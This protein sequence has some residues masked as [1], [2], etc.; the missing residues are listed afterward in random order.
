MYLSIAL[1]SAPY[2]NLTYKALPRFPESFWKPGL[3]LAIPLGKGGSLRTGILLSVSPTN[4]LP[5]SIPIKTIAWPLEESP[6]IPHEL[7]LLMEEMSKRQG[8]SIGRMAA[9]FLPKGLK[10]L[11]VSLHRVKDNTASLLPIAA[12]AHFDESQKDELAKEM[13]AGTAKILATKKQAKDEECF[14]LNVDPPWPVRPNA[15]VQLAVLEYLFNHGPK[16][17]KH[18]A[19]ALGKGVTAALTSLREANAITLFREESQDTEAILSSNAPL[20]A[21]APPPFALNADQEKAL[22]H[23]TTALSSHTHTTSLLYGVTGSGKTAVYLALARTCLQSGRSVLLLVPEVALALKIL[24]D[25]K[26]LY[27]DLPVVLYH[28]YQPQRSREHLWR[29]LHSPH[30]LLVIGTRSALF[31][32]IHDLGLIILDEEHDSSFKQDDGLSYH[33][34][35]IAWFRASFNACLLVLGSATP[36]VR[37]FYAAKQGHLAIDP[38]PTRISGKALPPIELV[39]LAERNSLSKAVSLLA[40]KSLAILE[41]TLARNEQAVILLNRRGYAPQMF[42]VA[43]GKT[44]RCPDCEIG[45]TYH[46]ARNKLVCHFCGYTKDFPS[47]CSHCGAATFLPLGEG[48]ERITEELSSYLGQN[49]LRLDRDTTRRSGQM[50]AIL[51]AFANQEAPVLVGTQMLSKGH[52]FPN[53]TLVIAANADMGLSMPDYRAVERTFQLLLQSAGRAGRGAL[54]GRV[55]LQTR[56]LG[57]Y[58]WPYILNYDYE[59]FFEEEL[60]RRK[61]LRYPPFAKLALIRFSYP[62]EEHESPT[63]LSNLADALREEAKKL[64]V[65]LLGPAP[66]PHPVLLGRNRFQCLLKAND[67]GSIRAVF[68]QGTQRVRIKHLRVSL[69]LDPVNML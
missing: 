45:L 7:I 35:E 47:P 69:D 55:L 6:L 9:G 5:P 50:E 11:S 51:K 18:L 46:K 31:L 67:W 34:K 54:Q 42:C 14:A 66:S 2:T 32:P 13:L 43:C 40:N 49:V 25:T 33:A 21:P 63:E 61:K 53:V 62:R 44:E 64:G 16:N 24:Q 19:S 52:H 10:D 27:P 15:K 41:E 12:I 29:S 68:S 26:A 60:A 22:A 48:T 3:R 30:P 36:D 23:L 28:G 59:H 39:N 20:L 56:D 57:H 38:L 17:R 4:P 58:C 1:L 37:T 65:T 8:E